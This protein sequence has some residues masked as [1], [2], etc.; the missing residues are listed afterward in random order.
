MC[1]LASSDLGASLPMFHGRFAEGPQYDESEYEILSAF[2]NGNYYEVVPTAEQFVD[3]LPQLIRA[4]DEPIAGPGL[5]P[6]YAVSK[7]RVNMLPS[8]LE[9]K[10]AM[11]F[12]VDMHVTSLVT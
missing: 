7:L 2:S 9:G 1:S 6:Q 11:K 5:F 3:Q 10:V 4:L 12:L 8:F